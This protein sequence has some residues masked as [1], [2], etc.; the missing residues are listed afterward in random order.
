MRLVEEERDLGRGTDDLR[1]IIPWCAAHGATLFSFDR[2]FVQRSDYVRAVQQAGIRV[3]LV[4]QPL[5]ARRPR[6]HAEI[7]WMVGRALVVLDRG[8][9]KLE[10]S[11]TT[12]SA[13]GLP[14][15]LRELRPRSSTRAT[16][17]AR[18]PPAS[19]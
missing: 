15:L 9:A 19:H 14:K 8:T 6:S 2:G 12:I 18:Q 4:V 10:G 17:R 11:F 1:D 5:R 13:A 7:L 16:G 3:V